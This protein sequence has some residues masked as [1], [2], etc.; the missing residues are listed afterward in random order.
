M[1]LAQTSTT[2]SVTSPPNFRDDFLDD[3][4]E[5]IRE[6]P[7]TPQPGPQERAIRASFIEQLLFGGARGG[8]KTDFLIGDYASDVLSYG[9]YW[10]GII[11]RH[12]YAELDEIVDR[13]KQI[14][15]NLFPGTEFKVGKSIFVMPNGATL[16]LRHLAEDKDAEHYQG[17]SYPWIGFDELPNWPSDAAYRKL[18][19]C[20]RSGHYIP[21]KRIRCTGNPGGVGHQWVRSY[22]KIPQIGEPD[23]EL[24]TDVDGPRLFIRSLV[25]DNKILLRNDP[26]YVDR[27]RGVGDD[28]L[29]SAWLKGDWD[30]FVG[31]YFSNWDSDKVET[32]S[33]E[34]PDD[35]PLIAAMD[36][37]ESNPTSFGL[38][39][40][41]FDGIHYRIAEYYTGNA[42]AS[43]HA[44]NINLLLATCPFITGGRRPTQIFADPSMW[45][46]RR[47]SESIQHSP[48]EIFAEHGLHLTKANND[49]VTGWRII[50]DLL[51]R[52]K[53]K[54]F[55]GWNDNLTRTAPAA[56]RCNKNP[57][58]IDTH[59][60]DHALDELRYFA[61][62]AYAPSAPPKQ[63]SRNPF[64]GGN[65]INQMTQKKRKTRRSNPFHAR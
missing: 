40:T 46:K 10:R 25:T 30:A 23:G 16:R 38:Y 13:G 2:N 62:N 51:V 50:N 1:S 35:W 37:G 41:D 31:Q 7:W 24:V 54:T 48:A 49:R 6:P 9:R 18:K 64:L 14:L 52:E 12:T 61:V 8:G 36:Y 4:P 26:D 27:L 19:A 60:E 45:V 57:E 29:V 44:Y 17:H 22:F 58:D 15:Y 21:N 56:P 34:I 59:C 5:V 55:K 53:F 39:T 63:T 28:Q 42:S 65:V 47:L 3:D 32:P 11:F 33:F 43:E 20:L